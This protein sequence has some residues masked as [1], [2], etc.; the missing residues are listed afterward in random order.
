MKKWSGE[1]KRKVVVRTKCH[2]GRWVWVLCA[3][4]G[5]VLAQSKRT[6]LR[7]DRAERAWHTVAFLAPGAEVVRD[8]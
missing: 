8:V 5:N 6:F 7:Q 2:A 1:G 3:S 4:N